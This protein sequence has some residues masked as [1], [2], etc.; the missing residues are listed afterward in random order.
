MDVTR[1]YFIAFFTS[2]EVT[3]YTMTFGEGTSDT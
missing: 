2:V 3:D 1:R